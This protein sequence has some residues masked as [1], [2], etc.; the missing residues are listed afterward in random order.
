MITRYLPTPI[1]PNQPANIPSRRVFKAGITFNKA[2]T[3][4][5]RRNKSIRIA[6]TMR[7]Q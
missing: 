2:I 7:R 4:G 6:T 1:G 5:R 3:I